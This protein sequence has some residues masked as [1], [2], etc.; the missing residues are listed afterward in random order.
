M[1]RHG[2]VGP[3]LCASVPSHAHT[4][5]AARYA[6][7]ICSVAIYSR[8]LLPLKISRLLPL[9]PLPSR[10]LKHD[11]ASILPVYFIY[12]QGNQHS[13]DVLTQLY[14]FAAWYLLVHACAP[15]RIFQLMWYLEFHKPVSYQGFSFYL[16]VFYLLVGTLFISVVL[17]VY[18][19]W[20]F[21]NN[22]FPFVWPIKARPCGSIWTC[23]CVL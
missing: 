8:A 11:V 17:C 5:R 4:C 1:V 20:C 21:K 15:R 10:P 16:A 19:A 14:S 6:P 2:A 22:N 23:Y 7:P 12:A 13:V 9:V 3:L 18:T